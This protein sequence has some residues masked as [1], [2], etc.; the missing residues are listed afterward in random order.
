M[1]D[2]F[3]KFISPSVLNQI[4]FNFI[5]DEFAPITPYGLNIKNSLTIYKPG[6]EDKLQHEF[7]ILEKLIK[8]M[9]QKE[10]EYN[11][12]KLCLMKFKDISGS[13]KRCINNNILDEVELFEIKNLCINLINFQG[14][15]MDIKLKKIIP[16]LKLN[17]IHPVL[18][19]LDPEDKKLPTFF[20]YDAYSSTLKDIRERKKSIENKM[21]TSS[22]KELESLKALRLNIVNEELQEELKVKEYLSNML[23]KYIEDIMENLKSLAEV[24]ILLAKGELAIKYGGRK[25]ELSNDLIIHMDSALNPYIAKILDSKGRTFTKLCIELNQGSTVITGANMGGKTVALKTLILNILLV[26]FG[27]FP[28]CKSLKL[29]LFNFVYFSSEDKQNLS[30]GLSSFGGEIMEL[31]EVLNEADKGRALIVLDEFAR[32]TNPKEGAILCSSVTSYMNKL[33]SIAVI[34]T[35]Y[36]GIAKEG[37]CHYQ[38]IGLKKADFNT[39]NNKLKTSREDSI[40]IIQEYMDFN[41]EKVSAS[42]EVPKD[43]L[44]ICKLLNFKKEIVESAVKLYEKGD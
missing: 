43:A 42:S 25:P 7:L 2:Y 23:N 21:F 31:N 28:F 27:F 22:P 26:H 38:C 40:E 20:I 8:D 19:L 37:I 17:D 14:L 11:D 15:C 10:K 35:H 36:H 39:L 9:G 30:K 44:N 32:G 33:N 5:M 16:T 13:I 12:L 6:E 41:L 34:A 29:C 4:G 24:D 18:K 1:K 3:M